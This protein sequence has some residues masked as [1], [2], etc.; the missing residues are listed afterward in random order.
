MRYIITSLIIIVF[1]IS[2]NAQ[3]AP[4]LKETDKQKV[5]SEMT[6]YEDVQEAL[7]V[8][9]DGNNKKVSLALIVKQGTSKKRAME[10]GDFFLRHALTHIGNEKETEKTG[11]IGKTFYDYMV[12]V[13]TERSVILLGKKLH[14]EEVISW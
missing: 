5:T 12:S 6:G 13:C 11:K 9:Q 10:L 8:Q 4:A 3:E 14:T 7:V 1:S 2:L